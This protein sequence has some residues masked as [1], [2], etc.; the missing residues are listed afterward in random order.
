M[1]AGPSGLN[2]PRDT[3]AGPGAGAPGPG[4]AQLAGGPGGPE[5]EEPQTGQQGGGMSAKLGEAVQTLMKTETQITDLA[6]QFPAAAPS[7]R[8]AVD[9]LR[10]AGVGLRAALRQVMTSPGAPEPPVPAIGG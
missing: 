6:R 1:A 5:P 9:G 10:S 4:P 7:F 3:N 8:Q 2:S